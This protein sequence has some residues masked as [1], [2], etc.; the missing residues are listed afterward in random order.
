MFLQTIGKTRETAT[1][2]TATH[3]F[4]AEP[5]CNLSHH[6]VLPSHVTPRDWWKSNQVPSFWWTNLSH[7]MLRHLTRCATVCD[8]GGKKRCCHADPPLHALL[9]RPLELTKAIFCGCHT[10][11]L[12]L[13]DFQL[14]T[15]L[16][17][18]FDQTYNSIVS[19][20]GIFPYSF[21]RFSSLY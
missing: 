9:V 12:K 2:C 5:F 4:P 10:K 7:H 14:F 6:P 1:P 13:T 8:W 18:L 3:V 17:V 21:S 19:V 11:H 15:L 20:N 16:P